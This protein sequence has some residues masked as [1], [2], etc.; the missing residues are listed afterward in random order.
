[1][2]ALGRI[3]IEQIIGTGSIKDVDVLRLRSALH[4]DGIATA[5]DAELL[6]GLNEA[7]LSQHPSWADL[8]VETLTDY[9]VE[10]SEPEGYLTTDGAKCLIERVTRNGPFIGTV[11]LRRFG[12]DSGVMCRR[13]NPFG[14]AV[15]ITPKR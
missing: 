7:C 6:F 5:A 10:Q 14:L 11:W 15:G 13:R 8:F 12:P 1:M 9:L 3:S 4:G 2:G